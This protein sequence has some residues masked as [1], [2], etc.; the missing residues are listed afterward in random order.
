MRLSGSILTE[1]LGSL[2]IAKTEPVG[3]S[4]DSG[5]QADEARLDELLEK[6][7]PLSP[8]PGRVVED[9]ETL[10]RLF[11]TAGDIGCFGLTPDGHLTSHEPILFAAEKAAEQVIQLLEADMASE[12]R[13]EA[14]TATWLGL[15]YHDHDH[16]ADFGGLLRDAGG[17]GQAKCCYLDVKGTRAQLPGNQRTKQDQ[18]ARE[19]KFGCLAQTLTREF[20]DGYKGYPGYGKPGLLVTLLHNP[21]VGG[22]KHSGYAMNWFFGIRSNYQATAAVWGWGGVLGVQLPEALCRRLEATTAIVGGQERS[23]LELLS[24]YRDYSQYKDEHGEW[25]RE[26][27]RATLQAMFLAARYLLMHEDAVEY[28]EMTATELR[29][30]GVKAALDPGDFRPGESFAS[31]YGRKY[32]REIEDRL[33]AET[34]KRTAEDERLKTADKLRK[35]ADELRRAERARTQDCGRTATGRRRTA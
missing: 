8:T 6:G 20:N 27:L 7:D 4:S 12:D 29:P 17:D 9:D 26:G 35:T 13:E 22:K 19:R 28:A 23:L 18:R 30:G 33:L 15:A 1:F 24:D 11:A 16:P 3:R 31:Y 2:G 25:D 14:L 21:V 10:D 5:E 34:E 32:D